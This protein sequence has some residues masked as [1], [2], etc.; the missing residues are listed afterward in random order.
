[1]LSRV[2]SRG[3]LVLLALLLP[4]ASA[5]EDAVAHSEGGGVLG[6]RMKRIDGREQ[7][8][9]AYRGQVLL[10]VNVASRCG[11]TPQYEGLEKLYESRKAR[12]FSVLGFPA[13]EFA[14]QEPGS[15][16]EIADFCR[17]RY[18]V[19]FPMF[20]KIAVQGPGIHPLYTHLTS[21]PAPLGGQIQWNFEK[22][23]VDRKGDVVA[24]FDPKTPPEDPTLV[25]KID[26]LLAEPQQP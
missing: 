21:L 11:L 24:R 7:E 17:T 16:A 26:S 14:A 25:A 20:S 12:G 18:G 2:R 4:G 23:L 19:S 10:L 8:L 6:F 15:D 9:A 13:N 5:A 3:A 22:F 1:M